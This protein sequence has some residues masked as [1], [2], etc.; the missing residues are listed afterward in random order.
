MLHVSA[1]NSLALTANLFESVSGLLL[2]NRDVC[3]SEFNALRPQLAFQDAGKT[4]G[5]KELKFLCDEMKKSIEEHRSKLSGRTD[6]EVNAK[7]RR[8]KEQ[9][10]NT[11]Q[12]L[13]RCGVFRNG[14]AAD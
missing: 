4:S 1:T 14:W 3:F 10:I 9:L 12:I 5:T 13:T 11:R 8:L 6:P 7:L 2:T